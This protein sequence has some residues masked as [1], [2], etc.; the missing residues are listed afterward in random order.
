MALFS[1][2]IPQLSNS[3]DA[4]LRDG[5][6]SCGFT[7]YNVWKQQPVQY[8]N[9]VT[10]VRCRAV[11]CWKSGNTFCSKVLHSCLLM[12]SSSMVRL[13]QLML[14]VVYNSM[15]KFGIWEA[16]PL[17]FLLH[18]EN[19]VPETPQIPKK[20]VRVLKHQNLLCYKGN[21]RRQ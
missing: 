6:S 7:L 9:N 16:Q 8:Q 5:T 1:C 3:P 17:G 4:G 19:W 2:L 18:F 10:R 11:E 14:R 12:Y 15:N 21:Q 20:L 13:D